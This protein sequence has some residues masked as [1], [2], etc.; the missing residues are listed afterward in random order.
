MADSIKQF[1]T[2]FINKG[3][4]AG[5][6]G[7]VQKLEGDKATVYIH[8]AD[9]EDDVRQYV[10]STLT[11]IPPTTLTADELRSL[12]RFEGG[13]IG[14]IKARPYA[15]VETETAY[16]MTIDDLEI[17]LQNIMASSMADREVATCWYYPVFEDLADALGVWDY[18]DGITETGENEIPGIL[19]ARGVFDD[20]QNSLDE[21]Y[22]WDD[23]GISLQELL[24]EIRAYKC[25]RDK[26]L[27]EREQTQ[28]QMECFLKTW[29]NDRVALFGTPDIE[30]MYVKAVNELAAKDVPIGLHEKAYACYGKDNV[31]FDEDW[32][33]SRDCLLK[34]EEIDPKSQYADTLGYIY[35]YGR[36]NGGVPEYEKAFYWFSIG[37]AGGIYESRYKLADMIKDGKGCHKD[38]E[39]A[40]HVIWDLYNENLKYFCRGWGRSKF[41][42]IALRVGNLY[43][44]GTNCRVDL[45]EAFWYYLMAKLAIRMRRQCCDAY[46]DASVE[47]NID[48]AIAGVQD[49]TR[50]KEKADVVE[51]NLWSLLR[52]ATGLGRRV[53]MDYLRTSEKK[54]RLTFRMEDRP[55][56][57]YA[58]KVPV[59]LP[60]AHFCGL[61]EKL[62]V[63]AEA[64]A[65]WGLDGK[66]GSVVFDEINDR[67]PDFGELRMFG[68]GLARIDGRFTVDCRKI[69]GESR[70]YVSVS[71]DD[72]D[73]CWD[74]LCDDED[75]TIGSKVRVPYGKEIKEGVVK[76]VSE[77]YDCEV[78]LPKKAY[79]RVLELI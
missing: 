21:R 42:D 44:D 52:F 32:E 59:L 60:E 23:E 50:Y 35:Y 10:L 43:R 11:F 33:T 38:S 25:D 67:W 56:T 46:G 27:V 55:G 4:Y 2:V 62:V 78:E 29:S 26:P 37:A 41:A 12:A 22:N 3:K 15:R 45:D 5:K 20:V 19:N 54:Y 68:E 28:R 34:L 61:L 36:C 48:E 8:D 65:V 70:R 69:A 76:R 31:G 18:I 75:V 6:H 49:D 40:A 9:P 58:S 1:D 30:A 77:R 24:D 64:T 7:F 71:F 13:V 14:R 47:R 51:V 53:R 17:A 63:K 74:Y 73:R 66:S 39:I 79:K 57:R 72:P 16:Q